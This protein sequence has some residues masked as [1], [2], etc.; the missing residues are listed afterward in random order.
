MTL[1]MLT[2]IAEKRTVVMQPLRPSK[3]LLLEKFGPAVIAFLVAISVAW[4]PSL[5]VLRSN[6]HDQILDKTVDVELGL[7]AGL[8]AIV[9]FLP[10]IEEKT[11]IRKLK[12]W[13][14]YRQL[15]SYLKESIC[16]S[17][18]AMFMT[19]AIIIL[20]EVW[21]G[22]FQIDRILSSIWWGLLAYSASAAFR[23]VNLSIKSLLAE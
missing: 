23:I 15:V 2:N 19:L 20:P 22:N 1:A 5:W 16:A 21:R 6:W 14:W 8:I 11:I 13:G 12:Q 17:A 9:A 3:A 7:L 18:L 4:T 10:A